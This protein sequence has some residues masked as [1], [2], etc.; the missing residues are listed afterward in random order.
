[1]AAK[2]I[3][4]KLMEPRGEMDK[5]TNAVRNC[6]TSL[7]VTGRKSDEKAIRMRKI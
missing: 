7:L 4:Q 5:T 6:N 3:K 2:Y 1:M